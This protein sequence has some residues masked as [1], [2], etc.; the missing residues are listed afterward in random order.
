MSSL[1]PVSRR[2]TMLRRDPHR[3][4]TPTATGE[5]ADKA[6]SIRSA[7]S[8]I[9]SALLL[10]VIMFAVAQFL[11]SGSSATRKFDLSGTSRVMLANAAYQLGRVPYTV[12]PADSSASPVVTIITSLDRTVLADSKQLS[13]AFLT[14]LNS[15]VGALPKLNKERSDIGRAIA[16]LD[17]LKTSSEGQTLEVSALQLFDEALGAFGQE[18]TASTI[19][20]ARRSASAAERLASKADKAEQA[21]NK[22]LGCL[23]EC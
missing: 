4:G 3:A 21:A 14:D 5:A 10:V 20:D 8:A 23:H 11:G 1:A 9:G 6:R 2:T 15:P 17:A 22:A 16:S 13:N 18:L 19:G 12:V 7:S